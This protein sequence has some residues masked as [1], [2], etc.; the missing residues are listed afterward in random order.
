MVRRVAS[1]RIAEDGSVRDQHV[2]LLLD[3]LDRNTTLD[4]R[5][6]L[7][8]ALD[9][10]GR[11]PTFAPATDDFALGFDTNAAFRLGLGGSRGTNAVDYL[12]VRHSG[13]LIMPGQVLQEI[14][15]NSL[16]ALD[17]QA[18]RISKA[19]DNLKEQVSGIGQSL[20]D[21]GEAVEVAVAELV[22]TH[23]DW[24]DPQVRSI[25]ERTMKVFLARASVAQVPRALFHPVATSRHNTKT[26]PGF[27]DP[28]GNNGDFFVWADFLLGAL[29]SLTSTTEAVVFVTNDSKK[30]WS[31]NG[32]S[33][34][35]L[36]A[37]AAAVL[38]RPFHMLSIE[39]FQTFASTRA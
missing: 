21:S 10:R 4:S 22:S 7:F 5:E 38:R 20:G 13:P 39:Q 9:P 29:R 35:V 26:P 23:G 18:K 17:P 1:D 28:A 6:A 34:P 14:W 32:T 15:N 37:E 8:N 24:I 27:R 3:L 33:H 2:T 16:E 11:I 25:F 31:R 12:D 30:D 19:M 36:M